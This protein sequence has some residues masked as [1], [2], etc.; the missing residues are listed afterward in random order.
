MPL[1]SSKDKPENLNPEFI[2]QLTIGRKIT[3]QRIA[4]HVL[5]WLWICYENYNDFYRMLKLRPELPVDPGL[6][7]FMFLSHFVTTLVTYYIVGYLVLPSL[8]KVLIYYYA[9]RKVL[10]RRIAFLVT[11]F[12]LVFLLFN[13]YDYY[14]FGYAVTHYKP[15]P[16]FIER[17]AKYVLDLGPFA[18]LHSQGAQGFIW[19]FNLSYLLLPSQLRLI[20]WLAD[21]GIDNIKKYDQNQ[22]LARNQLKYLQD[23]INPHFLFNVL[24]NLYALIHRTNSEA[25]LLLRRLIDYLRYTLYRTHDNFVELKEELLFLQN[26]V[27]IEQSRLRD[28]SV[29]SFVR[30]GN[31]DGQLV[32]PL[33]L[34]TFIENAFKH[35]IQK[36][37]QDGWID[38]RIDILEKPA[39]LRLDIKNSVNSEYE[40]THPDAGGLGLYNARQR[41]NL[42]FKPDEYK[43]I[44][45]EQVNFYHVQLE[46]PLHQSSVVNYEYEPN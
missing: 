35:G 46:I 42:L 29:I 27:E 34:L 10:W 15:V 1:F 17:N 33:L 45:D 30:Q 28:P 7:R 25:A 32:P 2:Q 16:G 26:Y 18:F 9:T 12:F 23:Q 40:T 22:K 14:I 31:P 13:V 43:C 5:Y 24:N 38:I 4:I 6:H 36:S 44:I 19:A 41:L 37:Y 3:P 8:L 39:L 20:R 11:S 21:W